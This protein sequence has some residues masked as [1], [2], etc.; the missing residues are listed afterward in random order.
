MLTWGDACCGGALPLELQ[1]RLQRV[2]QI[3][4]SFA[5]FAA[6]LVD[7]TVATWG[8]PECGGNLE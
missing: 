6:I 8:L 2:R 5:A 3:E 1:P 4:A 7:E